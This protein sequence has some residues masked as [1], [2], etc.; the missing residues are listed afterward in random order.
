MRSPPVGRADPYRA[1]N[2]EVGGRGGRAGHSTEY[3]GR[4]ERGRE[5]AMPAN[6]TNPATDP[7]AFAQLVKNGSA[8]E[9]RQLM[10][11]AHRRAVLEEIFTHMP[12]VFRPERAGSLDTVIHWNVGDRPDGGVDTFEVVIAN[13]T[14]A[15]SAQ[16]QREPKL[17]LNIGAVDFIRVVT[18][19]ANPLALFMRGKMKAKGDLGLATK[20]PHLFEPPRA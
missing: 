10:H 8:N 17:A 14:C 7:L 12:D 16:P 11:G 13:G 5:T 15:L 18:G 2:L 4:C 6:D 1:R 20:I 3:V 9:L 19:N